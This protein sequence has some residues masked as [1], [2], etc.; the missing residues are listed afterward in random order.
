MANKKSNKASYGT[1]CC[2]GKP[3]TREDV[4]FYDLT[5]YCIDCAI[6]DG[7]RTSKE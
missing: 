6:A 2:C 4:E 7:I 1:C 5:D 3:L